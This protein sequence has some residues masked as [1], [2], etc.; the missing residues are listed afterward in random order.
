LSHNTR[1]QS[2]LAINMA[3]DISPS[4]SPGPT[5]RKRG[6]PQVTPLEPYKD[7]IV[8]L[9]IDDDLPII[10][11]ARRLNLEHGLDVSERTISRRLTTWNVPRKKQ[12]GSTTQE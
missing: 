5:P 7:L 6:R 2:Q 9:F 3:D 11:I 1:G 10:D 8:K 4:A 12:K